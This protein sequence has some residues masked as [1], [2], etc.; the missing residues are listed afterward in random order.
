MSISCLK[1]VLILMLLPGS[2]YAYIDPGTGSLLLQF[3]VA[4][5]LG[6]L[7]YFRQSIAKIVSFFKSKS[8]SD[9]DTDEQ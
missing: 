7:F 2:V 9:V 4:G 8:S 3:L 5:V 6:A 1:I